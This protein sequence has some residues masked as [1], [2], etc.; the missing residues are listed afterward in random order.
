[1]AATEQDIMEWTARGKRQGAT[2]MIVVCD[3]FSYE[4]YPVYVS[5]DESLGEIRS[6]YDDKN[7]QRI[8]E[9]VELT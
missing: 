9:V 1:M 3:T 7:M 8:M 4:D 5:P 6:N 2:H